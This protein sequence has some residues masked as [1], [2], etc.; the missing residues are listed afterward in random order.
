MQQDRSL[1]QFATNINADLVELSR[2]NAYYVYI[3]PYFPILPPPAPHQV[4]DR[5]VLGS[6][7]SSDCIFTSPLAPDYEP[8]TPLSLALS[9]T[10][11]LIPHPSDPSPSS[12]ESTLLRREQ[13]QAFAQATLQSIEIESELLDSSIQPAEALSNEQ[14]PIERRRFHPQ[15][16]LE[17]ESV[18]ALLMLS[19]YEYAQRG[20]ISKMRNRA[21]QAVVK[22]MELGL[23]A[24]GHEEGE[25]GEANRRAWWMTVRNLSNDV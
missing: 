2:L 14:P 16:P 19:T 22:A 10:L 15:A 24:K 20:N 3:H 4:I 9:A 25:D 12:V 21:G 23:H 11:A 6:R 18:L 5:P 7:I 17:N 8:C 13:A 1:V